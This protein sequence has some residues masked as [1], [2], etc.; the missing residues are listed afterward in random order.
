MAEPIQPR[1]VVDQIILALGLITVVSTS[2][3]FFVLIS[4]ISGN[5]STILGID[6]VTYMIFS[7]SPNPTIVWGFLI[8]SAILVAVSLIT[9]L[10][11]Q[12]VRKFSGDS[13]DDIYGFFK[14]LAI[15]VFVQ[16]ILSIF[17][18]LIYPDFGMLPIYNENF[19][20]QNYF[21]S[22]GSV[23]QTLI[24]Q[25]V[26]LTVMIGVYLSLKRKFNIRALLNPNS[27]VT[28]YKSIFVIIATAV[29]ALFF[30]NN[31]G[32]TVMAYVTF[33]VLNVIY[34]RFGFFRSLLAGFAVTEFNLVN[35][36]ST[37][38]PYLPTVLSVY[39]F[40]WAFFGLL[41]VF[42]YV[43]RESMKRRKEEEEKRGE[44]PPAIEGGYIRVN[45]DRL[46]IRSS[47][48]ECGR[49]VFHVKESMKLVCEKCAH[50]LS[51]D[52]IGEYNIRI[53]GRYV[54]RL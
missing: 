43:S 14:Y 30:T 22:V 15:F 39:L 19:S 41:V 52:A 53:E 23:F 3:A 7:F 40:L 31:I 27:Y 50:E 37:S 13:V 44:R 10:P 34:L 17:G 8:V 26:P 1:G 48:P 54:E 18:R 2:I 11:N 29:A 46:F 20:V 6:T 5:M 16:L 33:L 42:E 9:I 47:C 21:F 35:G 4:G 45:P 32:N 12:A 36:L 49:A 24:L 25:F 51:S 38:I 28:E